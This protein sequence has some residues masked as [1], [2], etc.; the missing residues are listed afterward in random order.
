MKRSSTPQAQTDAAP[1]PAMDAMEFLSRL[2][3]L[4]I[5]LA[6]AFVGGM[7]RWLVS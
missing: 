6:L 5:F 4:D 2:S 3:A 1:A 7:L